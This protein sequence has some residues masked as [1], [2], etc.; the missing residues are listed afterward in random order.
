MPT[1]HLLQLHVYACRPVF[2]SSW[3]YV[4]LNVS[5]CLVEHDSGT[6][7]AYVNGGGGIR[8]CIFD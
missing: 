1:L 7:K 4:Q 2:L 8:F 5:S 6:A 3:K